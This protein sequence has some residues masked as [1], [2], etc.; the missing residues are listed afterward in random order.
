MTVS[1]ATAQAPT[2]GFLDYAVD[3][4]KKDERKDFLEVFI[5]LCDWVPYFNVGE[6]YKELAERGSGTI[7]TAKK[8][9]AI[10]GFFSSLNEVR[11]KTS[12]FFQKDDDD[13]GRQLF[14]AS[15]VT[16]LNGAESSLFL[17]ATGLVP[18]KEGLKIAKTLFWAPIFLM[19]VVDFNYRI[20]QLDDYHEQ[21]AT[22]K[23][24]LVKNELLLEVGESGIKKTRLENRVSH[25]K[26]EIS[27]Y[28]SRADYTHLMIIKKV[29]LLAL[30]SL[31]LV[32]ILFASMAQGIL[33]API[34]LL[35]LSSS[36]L[37]LHIITY[38]YDRVLTARME[39]MDQRKNELSIA[40]MI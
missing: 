15:A 22:K 14:N 9:L 29:T 27:L 40:N 30:S 34:T 39:E 28:E 32:S 13:T 36:W 4:A 33:F 35:S 11:H 25:I 7:D 12:D 38:M 3:F 5:T 1:T 23:D 20:C 37:A 6:Q 10:P 26:E 21:I 16:V 24:D 18:L 17:D 19:E 2:K 8:G 31:L